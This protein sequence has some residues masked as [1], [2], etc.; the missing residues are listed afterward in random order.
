MESFVEDNV[1]IEVGLRVM[2]LI[3]LSQN[4]DQCWAFVDMA[5]NIWV[6]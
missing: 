4:G 1:I 3:N 6:P 5:M 2:D